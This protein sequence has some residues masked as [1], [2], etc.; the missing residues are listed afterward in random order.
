MLVSKF[1][2]L[3][4]TKIKKKKKIYFYTDLITGAKFI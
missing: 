4:T 2:F 1:G 3:L